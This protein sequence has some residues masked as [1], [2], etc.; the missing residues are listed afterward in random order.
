MGAW[1][2]ATI[3]LLLLAFSAV[4]G[5]IERSVVTPAIFF[6][7]RGPA[8]RAGARPD[9]SAYRRRAG[10]AAGRG[11]ADACPLWGRVADL[12]PRVTGRVRGAGAPAR[13]RP[14]A[15]DRRRHARRS[16]RATRG[17]PGRGARSVDHA[18][19]HRR[20]ARPGGR[21]RRADPVAD[22]AGPQRR[23]R[24][25]RRNLRPALL[26]RARPRRMRTREVRL[27]TRRRTSCW[28]RS[29]TASSL[30]SPPASWGRSPS[31]LRLVARS[32]SH[33]G[34]RY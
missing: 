13:D 2:V 4:S 21:D 31:G 34:C 16:G 20:S 8:G 14:A 24:A 23:E 33:T 27:P 7:V 11:D 28:R 10:Q 25:Q 17:Q 1:T 18:R 12:V 3:A 30:A 29:A 26:H 15:H 5:R 22:P 19:L 9:R 32:S 6:T